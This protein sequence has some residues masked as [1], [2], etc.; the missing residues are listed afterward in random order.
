[1]RPRELV[2]RWVEAF[3]R[4]DSEALARFYAQDAVNHQVAEQPVQ[5][6]EAIR[7]MFAEGFA[8]A[9]MAC[10]VE[11]LFEEG[12]WAILEWR[13][14]LGLRGCGFFRVVAGEIALQRGYWDKLS[15]L[16]AQ[17][18]PLEVEVRPEQAADAGAI[19]AVHAAAFPTA[20]EAGLVDAL[21]AAGAA[22]VSEVAAVGDAVVGHVLLSPVS[23]EGVLGLAPIAVLP[24]VQRAGV[25]AAL[26]RSA[27]ARARAQGAAAIVLVGEPAY[28][29]RFG[30]APAREFGLRCKW[31]GTEEAFMAIELVPGALGK[32]RQGLV[33]YHPAFD[34]GSA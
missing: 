14:P 29:R 20:A 23:I 17:G 25:G 6:R 13:D 19:R 24:G 5:G 4:A 28:Y 18:T 9:K 26:M 30:F 33:S 27:L 15:F 32:G 10:I 31:A 16:R 3:N 7:R 1:M 11:N 2:E 8:R 22:R 21:R 34:R 12:D